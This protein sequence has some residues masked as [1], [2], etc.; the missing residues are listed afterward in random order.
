M[1]IHRMGCKIFSETAKA[2]K[3][4]SYHHRIWVRWRPRCYK[5]SI[6]GRIAAEYGDKI[7][8]TSDNPR[9]EDR[10][11]LLRMLKWV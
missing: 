6:M 2:I 10:H 4:K 7:Y 11:K 8:V 5:T 9:T 1:L 3:E